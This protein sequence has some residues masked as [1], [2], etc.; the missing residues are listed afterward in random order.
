VRAFWIFLHLLGG[1]LWIGGG[2]AA[3]FVS[4]AAKK[5][6]RPE[7]GIA[8]RLVAAVYARMIAPGAGIIVLSGLFLTMTYM[9]AMNRGEAE[10]TISPWVMAMQGLGL[11]GAAI[12]FA[13]ALPAVNTLAR[14]DPVGQAELFDRLRT[15]Q[16]M[17]G[18][19]ATTCAFV[20]L[21]AG[22]L[23]R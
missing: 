9:G 20:S 1:V 12:I 14:L 7:Q 5:M 10:M 22:A 23:Y 6:G 8:A 2:L 13:V 11:V 18:M 17:A 21:L 3:M 15:K 16:R 19:I 4:L